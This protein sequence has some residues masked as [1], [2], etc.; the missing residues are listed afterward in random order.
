MN[1]VSFFE[2]GS[3]SNKIDSKAIDPKDSIWSQNDASNSR[4]NLWKNVL[5]N[6]SF[7]IEKLNEKK[8]FFNVFRTLFPK[9]LLRK[10]YI[11]LD[12]L[13]LTDLK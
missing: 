9:Q 1:Y 11:E 6:T 4:H 13:L 3:F 12:R 7:E 10:K 2:Q 5:E 8:L